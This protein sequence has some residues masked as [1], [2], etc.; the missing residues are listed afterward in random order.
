MQDFY[1]TVRDR[2]PSHSRDIEDF[3]IK[4]M[5]ILQRIFTQPNEIKD[6][7][8]K[9]RDRRLSHRT[10]RVRKLAR[11][12]DTEG[13]LTT[14]VVDP[15]HLDADPDSTFH[16]DADPD[17]DFLFDTDPVHTFYP[18]EDPDPTFHPDADQ[19]PDPDTSFQIKAQ[20]LEKKC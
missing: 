4:E 17:Y 9:L 19:N 8:K 5:G 14:S 11:Q 3:R 1:S 18:D 16:P 20:T 2:G 10:R 13:F 12:I 6:F 7:Y 15:H